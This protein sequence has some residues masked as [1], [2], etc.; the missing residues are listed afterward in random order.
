MEFAGQAAE[1]AVA[2]IKRRADNCLHKRFTEPW[3]RL[4]DKEKQSFSG[5]DK[6]LNI[7][8]HYSNSATSHQASSFY[9]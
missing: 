3:M 7:I 1:G 5:R 9:L 8:H 2:L 6:R 4:K